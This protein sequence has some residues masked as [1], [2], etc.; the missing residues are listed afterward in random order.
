MALTY[1]VINRVE[2]TNATAANIDFSN[3]PNTYTDLKLVLS[4]RGQGFNATDTF[5][6]FN[7]NT[8]NYAYRLLWK[9][10]NTATPT[11]ISASSQNSLLIPFANGTNS[12]GN[13]FS[14]QSIYIPNYASSTSKPISMDAVHESNTA[15]TWLILFAGLWTDTSPITSILIFPAGGQNWLQHSTATLYGI[16]NT[17]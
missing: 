6:R 9:D 11:S 2:V 8:A 12:L 17:V 16:N 15:D 5:L 14:N 10:G 1:T 13:T 4:L 7:S 3:I